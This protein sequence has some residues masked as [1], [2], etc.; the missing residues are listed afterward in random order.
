MHNN[1]IILCSKIIIILRVAVLSGA[2]S[3]V[4]DPQSIEKA[5]AGGGGMAAAGAPMAGGYGS[6]QGAYGGLGGGGVKSENNAY[7]GSGGNNQYGGNSGGGGGYGGG[8]QGNN[9][10]G[11]YGGGG[12]ASKQVLLSAV[13]ATHMTQVHI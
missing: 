7:G 10:Y 13:A 6:G 8:S 9:P 5:P 11:P 12:S 3:K 4:G 1:A 2:V